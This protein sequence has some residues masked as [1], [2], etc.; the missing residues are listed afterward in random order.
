M[1]EE[2]TPDEKDKTF[3]KAQLHSDHMRAP[4]PSELQGGRNS[5]GG[6]MEESAQMP[7]VELP[8]DV[9]GDR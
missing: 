6:G 5:W 8:A 3:D 7:P 4:P 9:A 2:A 1:V